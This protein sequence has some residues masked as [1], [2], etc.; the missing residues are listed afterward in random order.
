[1]K[2]NNKKYYKT[3]KY[4]YFLQQHEKTWQIFYIAFYMQKNMGERI[5]K[6]EY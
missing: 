4:T 2:I 5:Q 1:M 6:L 3:K